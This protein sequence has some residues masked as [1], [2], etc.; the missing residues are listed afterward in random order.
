MIK[1][2]RP[3]GLNIAITLELFK[4]SVLLVEFVG[5]N[6]ILFGHNAKAIDWL[7]KIGF[8]HLKQLLQNNH[9][10]LNLIMLVLLL[11]I[12]INLVVINE[13]YNLKCWAWIIVL[14][15]NGWDLFSELSGLIHGKFSNQIDFSSTIIRII[16]DVI[17]VFCLM[18][19][20]TKQAFKKSVKAN[21]DGT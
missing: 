3:I 19:P 9:G 17:V 10:A 11:I 4:A 12:L 1:R 16:S 6:A 7:Q 18:M 20:S 13:L 21:Q 8:L 2:Q 5:V 14:I 15:L